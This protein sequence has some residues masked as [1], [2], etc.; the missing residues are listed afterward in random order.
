MNGVLSLRVDKTEHLGT[1]GNG[2]RGNLGLGKCSLCGGKGY[3]I[4][5]AKN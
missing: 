2:P 3:V 5:S 4:I 1:V